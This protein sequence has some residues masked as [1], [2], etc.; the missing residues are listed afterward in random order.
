MGASSSRMT[1]SLASEGHP[2]FRGGGGNGNR[3]PVMAG[4][5]PPSVASDQDQVDTYSVTSGG[6]IMYREPGLQEDQ[7]PGDRVYLTPAQVAL[8]TQLKS[9]HAELSRRIA[10]QQA[11][12]LRL[13]EQL[14]LTYRDPGSFFN[15]HP[16]QQQQQVVEPDQINV[17]LQQPQQQQQQQ[18]QYLASPSLS[19]P[20]NLI[21]PQSIIIRSHQQLPSNMKIV[22]WRASQQV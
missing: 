12:L 5:G 2:A 6:S 1:D 9:K 14:A 18:Q 20:P 3:P 11:E 22:T 21:Q 10:L 7:G 17:V 15:N 13:G 16:P 19:Q 4:G 8:Q